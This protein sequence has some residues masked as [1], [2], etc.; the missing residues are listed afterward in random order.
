MPRRPDIA[1]SD[2]R[3]R[4]L[5]DFVRDT[6]KENPDFGPSEIEQVAR[7]GFS[8]VVRAA[9][10]RYAG[11]SLRRFWK[12]RGRSKRTRAT[13]P[14]GVARAFL[15]EAGRVDL[16]ERYAGE[17]LHRFARAVQRKDA[18]PYDDEDD[19]AVATALAKAGAV[20]AGVIDPR[21]HEARVRKHRPNWDTDW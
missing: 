9:R 11:D 2:E 13:D 6:R 20:P 1:I 18:D 19:L 10:K 3:L 15:S 8:D 17:K 12:S 16:L 14:Y 5:D 4:Q 21:R 7:P